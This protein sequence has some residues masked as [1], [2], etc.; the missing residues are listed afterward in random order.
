MKHIKLTHNP[1]SNM[2]DVSI[3]GEPILEGPIPELLNNKEQPIV[4]IS[5]FFTVLHEFCNDDFYSVSFGGDVQCFDDLLDHAKQAESDLK[6]DIE[7]KHIPFEQA[8]FERRASKL[9]MLFEKAKKGPIEEFKTEEIDYAFERALEPEFEVFVLATVGAGKSTLVNAFLGQD[10]QPSKNTACTATISRIED[11]DDIK[12]FEGRA[13][14]EGDKKDEWV[15]ADKVLLKKWNNSNVPLI[16]LRGNIPMITSN[17][18]R[19]VLVDTPGTNSAMGQQHKETIIS[20]V[21]QHQGII[22]YLIDGLNLGSSDEQILLNVVSNEMERRDKQSRDRFIFVVNKID[23]ID[24][25]NDDIP[26]ILGRVREYLEKNYGITNPNIYPISAR[27]SK[28]IRENMNDVELTKTERRDMRNG[29][30]LFTEES[31][32]NMTQYMPLSPTV[33]KRVQKR[34]DEAKKA[35]DSNE[36]AMLY[37]G[38]AVLEEVILEYIYKHAYQDRIYKAVMSFEQVLVKREVM[39]KLHNEMA[40]TV[41]ELKFWKQ[42]KV[43]TDMYYGGDKAK[44]FKKDIQEFQWNKSKEYAETIRKIEKDAADKIDQYQKKLLGMKIASLENDAKMEEM[45]AEATS[46]MT[47]IQ[48]ELEEI[49][50]FEVLTEINRFKDDYNQFI[51]DLI[52]GLGDVSQ[53]V[54]QFVKS[55]QLKFD[56]DIVSRTIGRLLQQIDKDGSMRITVERYNLLKAV[57][58]ATVRVPHSLSKS[59][60]LNMLR[61]KL[62]RETILAEDLP[63]IV[64]D[65]CK[66]VLV[67][68]VELNELEMSRIAR[69]MQDNASSISALENTLHENM[70]KRR[71]LE[72]FQNE[73]HAILPV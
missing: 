21:K 67:K 72:D 27:L 52:S 51:R 59:N 40:N 18:L 65:A 30:E 54:M 56:T 69:G 33:Y 50:K 9:R 14:Y 8:E 37:S 10:L 5:R 49:V 60:I 36:L 13:C 48:N 45:V 12:Y 44:Q 73:L 47:Y 61:S 4:W 26:S 71:W 63:G 42:M 31:D 16:E 17:S 55:A 62:A 6:I 58:S 35:N 34:I 32:M 3:D 20:A 11:H 57:L 7:M 43:I 15:K 53:S 25:E 29:I 2:T 39:A 70:I 38:V 23:E 24:P 64:I 41:D 46:I 68:Q 1:H 19:L 66:D 22:L 28:L